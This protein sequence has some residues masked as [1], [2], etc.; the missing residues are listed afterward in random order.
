MFTKNS[1]QGRFVTGTLGVVSGFDASGMPIVKTKDGLRITT[2]P[3]EWNLEEQGKVKASISQIPLPA[4]LCDDG[5]QEPRDEYGCCDYG[6][7]EGVL[8]MGRVRGT[9][10]GAAAL[11]C[12]SHGHS[13]RAPLKASGNSGEDRDFR[14]ASDAARDRVRRDARRRE[15]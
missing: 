1:P 6:P 9:L 15:N 4:R 13:S 8:N 11:W 10:A 3:M 2:E 14:A 12:I 5:A 7:L